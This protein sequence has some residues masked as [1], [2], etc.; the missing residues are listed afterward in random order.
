MD[1]IAHYSSPIGRIT[2]AERDGLIA[3][4]WFDGQRFERS[5]LS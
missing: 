2:I 3:G 5:I 4:L 1:T